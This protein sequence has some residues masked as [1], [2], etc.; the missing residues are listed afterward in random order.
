[1]ALLGTWLMVVS[2]S[3]IT[4]IGP[5][6]QLF[7][8]YN[9]VASH[10]CHLITCEIFACHKMLAFSRSRQKMRVTSLPPKTNARRHQ[11]TIFSRRDRRRRV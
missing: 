9:S 2:G 3:L 7:I 4:A 6:T 5:P 1:M 8:V 11:H 10:Q